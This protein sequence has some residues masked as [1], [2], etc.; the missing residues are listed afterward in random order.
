MVSS[1]GSEAYGPCISTAHSPR[2]NSH[3]LHQEVPATPSPVAQP[4][5]Y[6]VSELKGTI[7]LDTNSLKCQSWNTDE[8]LRLL[9]TN[10]LNLT[11]QWRQACLITRR[12]FSRYP[13]RMRSGFSFAFILQLRKLRQK[14]STNLSL[15]QKSELSMAS[16]VAQA[17]R[18]VYATYIFIN[19]PLKAT[20]SAEFMVSFL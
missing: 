19:S 16:P 1:P 10:T 15:R 3:V 14:R 4:S 9:P 17:S 11:Y 12:C 18:R 8:G 6:F 2:W 13:V 20:N 5:F 7:A